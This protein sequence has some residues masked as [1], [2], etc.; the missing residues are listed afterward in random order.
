LSLYDAAK[1]SSGVIDFERRAKL[2]TEY[3]A[4]TRK[5]DHQFGIPTLKKKR[6]EAYSDE[7][8]LMKVLRDTRATTAAGMLTKLQI[9]IG[10]N[11][12]GMAE[13]VA[14][15]SLLVAPAMFSSVVADLKRLTGAK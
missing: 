7:R 10:M 1:A 3:E 12:E 5:I 11:E 14:P 4:K 6:D 13:V 2:I 15:D 8:C 9:A